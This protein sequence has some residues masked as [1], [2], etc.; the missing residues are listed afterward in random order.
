MKVINVKDVYKGD[1]ISQNNEKAWLGLLE[2]LKMEQQDVLFDFKG[3]EVYEP[4]TNNAFKQ[5]ISNEQVYMKV[6]YNKKLATGIDLMC[7]L[8]GLKYGRVFN[9]E[10]VQVVKEDPMVQNIA[11]Q[12][13]Q[14]FVTSPNGDTAFMQVYRRFDQIS[15]VNAV[16]Y[17]EKAILIFSERTGIHN[18]VIGTAG[19]TVQKEV[20]KLLIDLIV[21]MH[22]K[23]LM[24]RIESK[25]EYVMEKVSIYQNMKTLK[26][27]GV[28]DRE[29]IIRNLIPIKTVG[30]LARY[31]SSK[32]VDEFGRQGN[33]E[34]I[35]IRA[36]IYEGIG[37]NKDGILSMK[38]TSFN[39]NTFYTRDHWSLENDGE[40]LNRLSTN[41]HLIPLNEIGIYNEFFGTRYH[42]YQP[43][44][45]TL[46]GY[47][48]LYSLD[49]FGRL[50]SSKVNIPMRIKLVLDDWGIEYNKDEL[51]K[52][53]IE[54]KR[55]LNE[56]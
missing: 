52:S 25:D 43:I 56:P 49:D 11:N 32:S 39:G 1:T 13:Q 20:I 54:T 3:V 34:P 14:Y 6:Y 29:Q 23:G 36:T 37:K 18:I 21:S 42:F 4:W 53:I 45:T 46:D 16:K 44:Q 22:N 8:G 24:V 48:T 51:L 41:E 27:L 40:V 19:I 10:A 26:R 50:I 17:I 5:F 28:K 31:R 33:G 12:L 15:S 2:L 35:S 30:M 7:K 55:I 47:T 38:F 9:E